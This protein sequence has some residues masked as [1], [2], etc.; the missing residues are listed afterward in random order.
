M[1][2]ENIFMKLEQERTLRYNEQETGIQA[3]TCT[4]ML[5]AAIFTIAKMR[6]QCKWPSMDEWI[7]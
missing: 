7:K 5:T 6:K 3:D 2:S 1:P 4:Q